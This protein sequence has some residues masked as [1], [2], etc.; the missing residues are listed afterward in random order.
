MTKYGTYSTID[1]PTEEQNEALEFLKLEFE[2]IG[3]DVRKVM[4]DHDFGP[5][6]SFEIDY[7]DKLN[8][9]DEYNISVE[10][11]KMLDEWHESADR[12]QEDYFNKFE[13]YL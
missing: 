11:Q 9:I 13:K 5:Y 10:Q 3:G 12:I 1:C 7:P 6:P 2:K 4:N 8:D